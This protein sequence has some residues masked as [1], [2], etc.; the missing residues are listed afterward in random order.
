M[1]WFNKYYRCSKGHEWQDEWDCLCNDRCPV[2]NKETE[3]YDHAEIDQTA[4][5]KAITDALV[6]GTGTVLTTIDPHGMLHHEYLPPFIMIIRKDS[7]NEAG[8][9]H[10]TKQNERSDNPDGQSGVLHPSSGPS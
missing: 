2:C 7:L 5:D 9:E 3:P 4:E 10:F 6:N 8:L 1:A